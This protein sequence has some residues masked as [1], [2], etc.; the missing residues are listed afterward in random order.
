MN[1]SRKLVV[2]AAGVAL[3]TV[4]GAGQATAAGPV[5]MG[6]VRVSDGG[7]NYAYA[8]VTYYQR[9]VS[10]TDGHVNSWGVDCGQAR[11]TFVYGANRTKYT[12]TRTSCIHEKYFGFTFDSGVPG[13][14]EEV[15]LS[16]FTGDSPSGPWTHRGTDIDVNEN[17]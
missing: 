9:S 15:H 2:L 16:L 7:G 3:S 12:T 6:V 14:V 1:N 11:F 5:D 8:D 13:G 10:I 4:V 17:N